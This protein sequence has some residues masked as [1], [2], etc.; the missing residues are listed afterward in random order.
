MPPLFDDHLDESQELR[1]DG[2]TERLGLAR[3]TN[4]N[5]L[6]AVAGVPVR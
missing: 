3:M 5:L 2:E 1:R 6:G 4:S